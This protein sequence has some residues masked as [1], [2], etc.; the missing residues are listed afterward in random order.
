MQFDDRNIV[1]CFLFIDKSFTLKLILFCS[2]KGNLKKQATGV[3]KQAGS[4]SLMLLFR[5]MAFS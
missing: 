4:S 3:T 1:G 5:D 2:G